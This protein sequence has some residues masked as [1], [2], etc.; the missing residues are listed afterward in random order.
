[1]AAGR[2]REQPEVTCVRVALLPC[3]RNASGR[4][5]A[6]VAMDTARATEEPEDRAR[7][8]HCVAATNLS[9]SCL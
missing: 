3:E 7:R 1:M 2:I 5:S 9:H 6:V 4:V 8:E